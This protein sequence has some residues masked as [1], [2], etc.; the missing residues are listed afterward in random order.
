MDAADEIGDSMSIESIT[1]RPRRSFRPRR[2]AGRPCLGRSRCGDVFQH[3]TEPVGAAF[4][5]LGVPRDRNRSSV[6]VTGRVE[7]RC[8]GTCHARR[9]CQNTS[10]ASWCH[11]F[12]RR[13]AAPS[14]TAAALDAARLDGGGSR[15][16]TG[17]PEGVPDEGLDL[18]Q[19]LLWPVTMRVSGRYGWLTQGELLRNVGNALPPSCATR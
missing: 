10:E 1:Q 13:Y 7:A 6:L 14:S 11:S 19:G 16:A 3:V 9:R 5:E 4:A 2:H 18:W 8:P 15:A 12:R 17:V